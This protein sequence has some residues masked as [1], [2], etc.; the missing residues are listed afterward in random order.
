MNKKLVVAVATSLIIA[1]GSS[2]A[3]ASG[4]SGDSST[5]S[6][7]STTIARP[8]NNSNLTPAQRAA[9][10]A[11][12]RAQ[13]LA[14]KAQREAEAKYRL[15]LAQYLQTRQAINVAFTT[16]MVN[17]QKDFKAARESATDQQSINIATR[18]RLQAVQTATQ[19]KNA[20]LRALGAP[21]VKPVKP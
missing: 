9:L 17:A 20:A 7:P 1:N 6:T 16:A 13:R 14:Q 10:Q 4:G 21:P 15:E 5:T 18:A 8:Q 3:M 11:A 12:Q 2:V 19:T